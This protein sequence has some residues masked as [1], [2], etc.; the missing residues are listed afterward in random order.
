MQIKMAAAR[1]YDQ[2]EAR[3]QAKIEDK[4]RRMREEAGEE[5][6][7]EETQSEVDQEQSF[8]G[9]EDELDELLSDSYELEDG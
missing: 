7:Q 6:W 1:P 4:W 2:A 5:E 3:E 9:E 8:A